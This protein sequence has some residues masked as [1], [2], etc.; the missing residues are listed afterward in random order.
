MLNIQLDLPVQHIS[1]LLLK[2]LL[3]LR[4]DRLIDVSV[5]RR[6]FKDRRALAF[7]IVRQFD[8]ILASLD[9]L[10]SHH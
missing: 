7:H 6:R 5:E 1:F 10:V 2:L 9:G 3:V 8:D 4:V